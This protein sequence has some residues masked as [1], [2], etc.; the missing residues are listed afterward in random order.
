MNTVLKAS[1]CGLEPQTSGLGNR[2]IN[3]NPYTPT[4][5]KSRGTSRGTRILTEKVLTKSL[6]VA[7]P[8]SEDSHQ[9]NVPGESFARPESDVFHVTET[10]VKPIEI[11]VQFSA[12]ISPGQWQQIAA[13]LGI[14]ENLSKRRTSRPVPPDDLEPKIQRSQTLNPALAV[15]LREAAKLLSFSSQTVRREIVRGTLRALKL[16]RSWRVR[17]SEIGAYL[18][19]LEEKECPP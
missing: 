10:I 15:D 1:P 19:R 5:L 12:Q 7:Y 17:M 13:I 3:V 2:Y 11:Q 18:Q 9:G 4:T 6:F 14:N 16:G 8:A